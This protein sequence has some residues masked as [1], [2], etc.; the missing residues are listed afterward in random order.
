MI[1]LNSHSNAPAQLA[2]ENEHCWVILGRRLGVFWYG[3]LVYL[4]TGEPSQV[5]FDW[6]M[7]FQREETKGDVVGFLHTHPNTNAHPSPTDH[8]TMKT[9]VTAMGKPLICSIDGSD[10][11][12]SFW[13]QAEWTLP[14][15]TR[16]R[17]FGS[18]VVGSIPFA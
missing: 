12:K 1:Q 10:G 16:I 17:K 4:A 7:V 18:W 6:D 3:R 5:E 9:W 15:E 11:L 2:A 8:A 14:T 13:Y